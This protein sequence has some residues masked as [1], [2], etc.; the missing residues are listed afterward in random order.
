MDKNILYET[1]KILIEKIENAKDKEEIWLTYHDL[2]MYLKRYA[3]ISIEPLFTKN[4]IGELSTICY[5]M[6]LPLISCIVINKEDLIPGSG[7]FKLY[8]ELTGRKLKKEELDRIWLDESEKCLR[9]KDWDKLLLAVNPNHQV[10][11]KTHK[12]K[13]LN[14]KKTVIEPDNDDRLYNEGRERLK[15]HIR[16]EKERNPYVIK[17]AKAAFLK[18]HGRLYCQICGFDF[19]EVYGDI[20]KNF[21]EGHH[22]KM[23]ADMDKEGEAITIDDIAIVCSNCHAMLHRCD[24]PITVEELRDI[25]EN[26]REKYNL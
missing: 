18:R 11:L 10:K 24:P 15:M 21:A 17:D 25:V 4:Y 3:G 22:R 14:I 20:G 7:F 9:C 16:L 26:N 1:A 13:P 19:K 12:I 6:G 2:S 23:I 5:R 8:G